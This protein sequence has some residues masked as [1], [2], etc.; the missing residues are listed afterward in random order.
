MDISIA[1]TESLNAHN[2]LII[3]HFMYLVVQLI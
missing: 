2:P 3:D 1:I